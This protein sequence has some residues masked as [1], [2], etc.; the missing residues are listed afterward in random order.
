MRHLPTLLL[1]FFV[2]F[3]F[4]FIKTQYVLPVHVE[5]MICMEEHMLSTRI[6]SIILTLL[7]L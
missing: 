5:V 6:L 3:F 7:L 1:Y 4:Y 2:S